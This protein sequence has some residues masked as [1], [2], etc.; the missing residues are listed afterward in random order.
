MEPIFTESAS[1][2]VTAKL[3]AQLA[4][5]R[6]AL[7]PSNCLDPQERELTESREAA[8]TE[9]SARVP[10]DFTSAAVTWKLVELAE[11]EDKYPIG[12]PK[13]GWKS[14]EKSLHGYSKTQVTRQSKSYHKNKDEIKRRREE[15]KALEAGIP[16]TQRPKPVWG[17][18]STLFGPHVQ[19]SS[20]NSPAPT[21]SSQ[22]SQ[23]LGTPEPSP[24]GGGESPTLGASLG[25]GSLEQSPSLAP[26]VPPNFDDAFLNCQSFHKEARDLE[27]WLKNQQGKVTGD[28]LLRI[29][30][31]RDLLQMQH[32][33]FTTGEAARRKDWVQYSEALARRVNRSSRWAAILRNWERDWFETRSPPPCPRR[34]K[35]V[36]RKS[37]YFEEGILLAVRG[38]CEAVAKHLQEANAAAGNFGSDSPSLADKV[39]VDIWAEQE[40]IL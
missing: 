40:K 4:R 17:K 19:P 26:Y 15:K 27:V 13:V 2:T 28:W 25:D 5:A 16:V 36:K 9:E 6:A 32:R 37:L 21:E 24:L 38:I 23:S 12:Q 31:L 29:D 14:A 22:H 8:N 20:F 18:I 30:C 1:E 34:G 7:P 10:D 39:G 33:K 3:A 11:E 35:H